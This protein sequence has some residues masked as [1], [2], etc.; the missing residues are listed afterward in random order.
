MGARRRARARERRRCWA[1]PCRRAAPRT[2]SAGCR[3]CRP[4]AEAGPCGGPGVWVGG[5]CGWGGGVGWGGGAGASLAVS[6]HAARMKQS[7]HSCLGRAVVGLERRRAGSVARQ[8][9]RRALHGKRAPCLICAVGSSTA[10]MTCSQPSQALWEEMMGALLA[11]QPP[12][13]TTCRAG[14]SQGGGWVSN[15]RRGAGSWHVPRGGGGTCNRQTAAY[16]D[17]LANEW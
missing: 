14:G 2:G 3:G 6:Q 10:S 16:K 12:V 17:H 1:G 7:G 5:W 8:A 9:A 11:G 13:A 4:P 15:M